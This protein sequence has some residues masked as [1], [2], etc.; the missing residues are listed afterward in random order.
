V[1]PL[2]GTIPPVVTPFRAGGELDLAAF[3]ANLESYAAEDLQGYLVLGSNGEAVTLE[4]AEKL[5]LVK[6]ARARSEG[7]LLLVGTG[8]EGT[9]ATISLTAKVADLGADAVLVLTPHY[10][11]SQMTVDLFKRHFA[12]VADASP[13][14]VLL[15]SVPAF[16]G[17]P[18]PPALASDLSGHPKI[19]GMKESSG[20]VALLS[21]LVSSVPSSFAIACGSAPVAYP[22]FCLGARAQVVALACCA[23]RPAAALYRAFRDGDHERAR[24][25]QEAVTPLASAVT[26]TYG[27][28]GLKLAMTLAGRKGGQVRPPLLQAPQ[29]IE[30]ELKALLSRAEA[31]VLA[32]APQGSGR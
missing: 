28:P 29:S 32:H 3:E 23:P 27:V 26:S 10:Y 14:P 17:I 15:Y 16:T 12:A 21:R 31:A 8:L 1:R 22:A 9:A 18:F 20:D 19:V 13:V 24:A 2:E 30:A 4:E 25:L 6:S 7:R 5:S 11:R